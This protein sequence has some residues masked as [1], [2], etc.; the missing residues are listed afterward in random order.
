VGSSLLPQGLVLE[1]F[2]NLTSNTSKSIVL[3]VLWFIG[4]LYSLCTRNRV[5][6]HSVRVVLGLGILVDTPYL[7]RFV[8]ASG[9]VAIPLVS[10]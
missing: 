4:L 7:A 8:V 10:L 6:I 9:E 5:I 1:S 3:I 2:D